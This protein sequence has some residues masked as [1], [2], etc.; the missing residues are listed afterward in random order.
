MTRN[1]LETMTPPLHKTSSYSIESAK[2]S[3]LAS[4][5]TRFKSLSNAKA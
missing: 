4:H 3:H 1:S 5:L 2:T